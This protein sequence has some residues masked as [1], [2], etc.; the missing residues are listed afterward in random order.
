MK[1]KNW[2]SNFHGITCIISSLPIDYTIGFTPIVRKC[3]SLKP[4]RFIGEKKI[5]NNSDEVKFLK[6]IKS[7]EANI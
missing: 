5:V 4:E 2:L 3:C 1:I 7:K 6:D